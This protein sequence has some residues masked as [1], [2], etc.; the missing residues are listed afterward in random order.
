MVKISG[1]AAQDIP[2]VRPVLEGLVV[3]VETTEW[4]DLFGGSAIPGAPEKK[5]TLTLMGLGTFWATAASS[6]RNLLLNPE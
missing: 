6:A 2:T 5:L 4:T 3:E 1:I